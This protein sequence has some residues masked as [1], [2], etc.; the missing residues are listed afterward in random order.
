MREE[1]KADKADHLFLFY[2][3]KNIA[4][5]FFKIPRNFIHIC[6]IFYL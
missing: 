6:E 1:R 4:S 5:Y 3:K 2:V